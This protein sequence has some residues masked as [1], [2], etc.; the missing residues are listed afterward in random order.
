MDF[1]SFLFF[2]ADYY[3]VFSRLSSRRVGS[4]SKCV[5]IKMKKKPYRMSHL[6]STLN[7]LMDII[8]IPPFISIHPCKNLLSNFI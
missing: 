1:D 3:K 6:R 7:A 8:K 4:I 5:K 2:S